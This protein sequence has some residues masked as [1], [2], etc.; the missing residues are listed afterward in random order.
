MSFILSPFYN[1]EMAIATYNIASSNSEEQL[2]VHL[3]N[4]LKTFVGR[5]I[6]NSMHWR[7]SPTL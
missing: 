1:K 2:G 6:K 3:Q 4:I 5:L 7:Q